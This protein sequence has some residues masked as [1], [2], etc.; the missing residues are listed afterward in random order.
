[1]R[2]IVY[3]QLVDWKNK[4]DRKLLVLNGTCQTGKIWLLKGFGSKE[5]KNLA[6]INCY[7]SPEIKDVFTDSLKSHLLALEF[8]CETF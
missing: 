1:M 8:W 5:Y 2:R 6:Y 4:D 3:E 7:E